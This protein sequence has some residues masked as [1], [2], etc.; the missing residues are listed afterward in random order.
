[1]SNLPSPDSSLFII[2]PELKAK[3]ETQFRLLCPAGD[4]L[5]GDQAKQI[6]LQSGLPP[7][8]LANIWSLADVDADGRMDINEFSIALHLIALKL[9]GVEL[10]RTL[11]ST[12]KVCIYACFLVAKTATVVVDVCVDYQHA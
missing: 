10:P 12:L 5:S 7:M 1:M 9:K 3:Y 8:I 11:P 4:Y 6:M 2:N